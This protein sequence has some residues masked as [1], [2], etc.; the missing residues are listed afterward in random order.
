MAGDVLSTLLSLFEDGQIDTEILPYLN[1]H[2]DWV[3]YRNNFREAVALR[4]AIREDSFWPLVEVAIDERQVDGET[5]RDALVEALS[6][7]S[8]DAAA[9]AEGRRVT[10]E[11]FGPGRSSIIWNFNKLYWHNLAQWEQFSGQEYEKALPSGSSDGHNPVAIKDSVAEFWTLLKDMESQNQ[12]PD[13][14]FVM[15]IG[16]GTAERA[17]QWLNMFMDLDRERGTQYYPK[18]RFLL[19]DYA[20]AT[21][22][23]AR[24][25]LHEHGEIAS[26]IVVDALDPFKTLSFLRYK[27][28]YI[29]L[30]NVYDNLPTDEIVLRDGRY[31]SVEVRAYLKDSE[32][33]AISEK[34]GISPNDLVRTVNRLLDVGPDHLHD[35]DNAVAFWQ[36]VWAGIHLEERLVAVDSLSEAQLPSGMRPS[37]L[38]ELVRDASTNIRFHLSSGAVESFANT[39]SLLH[40]RGTCRSK[41]FLLPSWPAISSGF[42]D[43]GRWTAR[44]SIG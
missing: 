11:P 2:M 29:H 21:L 15:E 16:V 37:H 17:L 27:I 40:P 30:T 8:L 43:R 23:R 22:D 44:S 38:E 5:L 12:L 14:F 26:F 18:I 10:L 3:Q 24:Q 20:M 9:E 13:E 42:A 39:I 41:T 19:A 1:V 6:G 33:Q 36:E 34:Y 32:V 35:V 25:K 28:L 7:V 4:R 31:F